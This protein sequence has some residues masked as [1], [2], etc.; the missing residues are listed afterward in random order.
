MEYL[1]AQLILLE[2]RKTRTDT[3]KKDKTSMLKQV[4]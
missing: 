3:F 4:R 2:Q 1:D